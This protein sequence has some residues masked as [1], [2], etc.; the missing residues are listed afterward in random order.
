ML[1]TINKNL[2]SRK[3]AFTLIELLVVIA[4]IGLLATLSVLA[5]NNAR[6]KSRDAKRLAD[7]KQ[8]QTALELYFNSVG[9]YPTTEEFA[10]GKI[11]SYSPTVGTTTYIVE[12]PS[13]PTPPDGICSTSDNTYIYTPNA[14]GSDYNL[15]FC[16]AKSSSNLPDGKLIAFSGGI[17]GGSV[18]SFICGNQITIAAIAGHACNAGAPDYDTCIYDTVSIGGQCWM[19]QNMNIGQ[20][21]AGVTTQTNDG[22]PQKYCYEDNTSNCQANGGLYQWD[23]AMQYSVAESAQGICPNGWHIPTDAEQNI[24]DQNLSDTTCD[25]NRIG[26]YDCANAGTKLQAGGTSHFEGLLAGFRY[27]NGLFD[28]QGTRADFW[29]STVSGSYSWVRDLYTA[30]PSVD[31]YYEDRTYGFSVRCLQN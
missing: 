15:T 10:S 3:S 19:K 18:S 13:A 5:L 21:V 22:N 16:V 1:L 24:L 20:Y 6:A 23:E 17:K 30:N 27:I 2:R 12:I 9:H 25:A 4:I 31:R 28:L 7:V 11:E 26:D 14:E 8:L 29:S